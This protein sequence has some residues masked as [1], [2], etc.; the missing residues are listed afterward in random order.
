MAY[1]TCDTSSIISRNLSELSGQSGNFLLST[2][3][4]MELTASAKDESQRKAHERLY[5]L[6]AKDNC[7]IIPNLEDWVLASKVLYW[8]TLGRRKSGG[9]KLPRLMPGASQRMAMDALI[10][11]GARRWNATLI[12]ENWDDF[13]AIQR[14][15]NVK[16]MKGSE[17]FS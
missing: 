2:V 11:V 9:G 4:L 6:Y 7:L 15:C 3:V 16:L 5:R 8:L 1:H 14:Y 10:A 13:K 17:F 12:T